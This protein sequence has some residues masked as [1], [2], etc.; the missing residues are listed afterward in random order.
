MI[1]YRE[2]DAALGTHAMKADTEKYICC[3]AGMSILSIH[4]WTPEIALGDKLG[5]ICDLVDDW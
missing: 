1:S 4:R 5:G 3:P 2:A